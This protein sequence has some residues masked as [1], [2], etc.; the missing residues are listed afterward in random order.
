MR[1][2]R[3]GDLRSREKEEGGQWTTMET[4]TA[5]HKGMEYHCQYSNSAGLFASALL[6]AHQGRWERGL[7]VGWWLVRRELSHRSGPVCVHGLWLGCLKGLHLGC[8]RQV[9][10]KGGTR[11]GLEDSR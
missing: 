4:Q 8:E 5:M 7:L 10:G 6:P 11:D 2:E 9:G 1:R 3:C